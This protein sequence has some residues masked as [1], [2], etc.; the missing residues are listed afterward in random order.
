MMLKAFKSNTCDNCD[1]SLLDGQTS[2]V[3]LE[4]ETRNYLYWLDGFTAPYSV[5][6]PDLQTPY[7]SVSPLS[8][9]CPT[10]THL[11]SAVTFLSPSRFWTLHRALSRR[12]YRSIQKPEFFAFKVKFW[13]V[14]DAAIRQNFYS[15]DKCSSYLQFSQF[16][17][18]SA[19]SWHVSASKVVPSMQT[20]D[21]SYLLVTTAITRRWN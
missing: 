10:F 12:T 20:G 15:E 6:G 16:H 9:S 4:E 19:S 7:I 17:S 3:D 2:R 18:P 8:L 11:S 21:C 5:V 14:L 1:V 13:K